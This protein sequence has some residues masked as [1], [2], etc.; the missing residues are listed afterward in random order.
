MTVRGD[1]ADWVLGM[2]VAAAFGFRFEHL[3]G[4]ECVTRLPWR[5]ELSHAPGAFQASPIGAL[6]DFTGAAASATLLSPGSS[7]ATVDYTVKFVAAARGRE[8]V[9]RAK[10]VRPGRTLTVAAVDLFVMAEEGEHLCAVAF[11]TVRHDAT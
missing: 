5:P 2:P 6:A 3:D 10:V 4:G 7:A 8:L 1:V 9:A 11:V